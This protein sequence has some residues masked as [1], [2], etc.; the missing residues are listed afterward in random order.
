MSWRHFVSVLE[1]LFLAAEA[2]WDVSEMQYSCFILHAVFLMPASEYDWQHYY[3]CIVRS[4]YPASG[5]CVFHFSFRMCPFSP[6]WCMYYVEFKWMVQFFFWQHINISRNKVWLRKMWETS[7]INL[8]IRCVK[9]LTSP[10][11]FI[12]TRSWKSSDIYT[13]ILVYNDLFTH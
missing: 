9:G 10:L 2:V 4:W 13:Y 3:F 6:W 7:S 12:N 1:H 11:L 8:V 5:I